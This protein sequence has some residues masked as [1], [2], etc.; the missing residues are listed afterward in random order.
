M[1]AVYSAR[2][3][4]WTA[5]RPGLGLAAAAASSA[6]STAELAAAYVAASGR[7][8]PG[9]GISRVRSL[10]ATFS[11]ISAWLQMCSTSNV[12]SISPAVFSLALWQ[13]TQYLLKTAGEE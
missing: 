2:F 9:G 10:V 4:R 1:A 11:Q 12:S 13:V 7:G 5:T 8:R 6:A 3:S